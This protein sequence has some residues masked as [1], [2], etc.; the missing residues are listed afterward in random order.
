MILDGEHKPV[1]SYSSVCGTC[2]GFGM[3]RDEKGN[4][5]RCDCVCKVCD[6]TG[7]EYVLPDMNRIRA[8]YGDQYTASSVQPAVR[9]CE[10]GA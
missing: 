10:C 2:N 5:E 1:K 6:G 9:R 7:W 3:K 8:V 4:Y